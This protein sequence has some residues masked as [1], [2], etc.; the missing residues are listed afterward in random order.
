M[1]LSM[2][3]MGKGN[4]KTCKGK[5]EGKVEIRENNRV[6]KVK[7][8]DR[9]GKG[10][11]NV[12]ATRHFDGCCHHSKVCEHMKNDWLVERGCHERARSLISGNFDQIGCE[13]HEWTS[14]G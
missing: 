11:T 1:D 12:N 3:G 2:M 6:E 5:G 7:D 14:H 13:D 8:K 4:G 9:N 10:K